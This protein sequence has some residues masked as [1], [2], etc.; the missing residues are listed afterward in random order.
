MF[1]LKNNLFSTVF[2]FISIIQLSIGQ[3]TSTD[4][5]SSPLECLFYNEE[6]KGEYLYGVFGLNV[7]R[8]SVYTWSPLVVKEFNTNYTQFSDAEKQ[9]I[10]VLEPV[11]ATNQTFLIKNQKYNEYLYASSLHSSFFNSRRK[12]FTWLYK[13]NNKDDSFRWR[14]KD[15][16]V[17]SNKYEIWNVKFDEPLFAASYFFRHDNLRRNVF[18]WNKKQ[19]DSKQFNWI[20]SCRN[21]RSIKSLSS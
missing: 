1:V 10:W 15:V 6:Y 12:V 3:Q 8:R 18:T 19:P 2:A 4:A 5:P 11:D 7:V 20:V 13:I 21:G 14:L 9:A 17:N 16:D